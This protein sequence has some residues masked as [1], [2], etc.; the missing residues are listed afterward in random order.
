MERTLSINIAVYNYNINFVITDD[1]AKSRKARNKIL[2]KPKKPIPPN[3]HGLH[4]YNNKYAGSFIFLKQDCSN[5]TIAH[6]ISHA[7]WHMFGYYG[8]A[9]EDEAVA[10]HL[11]YLINQ[12]D[13]FKNPI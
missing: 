3:V 5:G 9:L 7:I 8:V 12:F 2:G 6:E 4:D 1:V 13:N 11:S 10:Y